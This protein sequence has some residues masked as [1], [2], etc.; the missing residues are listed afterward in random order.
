MKDATGS[1]QQVGADAGSS[2]RN[3]ADLL[4]RSVPELV[5]Q[6]RA[7]DELGWVEADYVAG[8][9][10]VLLGPLPD[11]RK[12]GAEAVGHDV[13]GVTDENGEVP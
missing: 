11:S 1:T 13:I 10:V 9:V 6:S 12:T 4:V 8:E 7:V 5:A 2:D 3:D